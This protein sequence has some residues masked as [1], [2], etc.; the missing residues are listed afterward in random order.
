MQR[1]HP[2]RGIPRKRWWQT[3]SSTTRLRTIGLILWSMW[4][5]TS[6]RSPGLISRFTPEANI[7]RPLEQGARRPGAAH[8]I[9]QLCGM[10]PADGLELRERRHFTGVRRCAKHEERHWLGESCMKICIAGLHQHRSSTAAVTGHRSRAASG[11]GPQ[12]QFRSSSTIAVI[13]LPY[14]SLSSAV[15]IL[16]TAY[17]VCY[18]VALHQCERGFLLSLIHRRPCSPLVKRPC[19]PPPWRRNRGRLRGLWRPPS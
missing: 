4:A 14:C 15:P 5:I 1:W 3:H 10:E 16:D 18:L 17:Y 12:Q 11:A 8:G 2:R 13:L 19:V 6:L 7:P 9:E